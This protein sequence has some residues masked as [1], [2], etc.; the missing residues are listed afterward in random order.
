MST[1][2]QI[3]AGQLLRH[4]DSNELVFPAS[5]FEPPR[6]RF[7]RVQFPVKVKLLHYLLMFRG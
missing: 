2:K 1:N 4:E 7:T 3:E 5:C 6:S